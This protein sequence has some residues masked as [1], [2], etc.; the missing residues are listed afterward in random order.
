MSASYGRP[1]GSA[2]PDNTLT[3]GHVQGLPMIEAR[4]RTSLAACGLQEAERLVP[5]LA[6]AERVHVMHNV[7]PLGRLRQINASATAIP[8]Y[9]AHNYLV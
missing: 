1:A 7:P 5:Q 3:T 4:V 9:E 6:L 2:L 8:R